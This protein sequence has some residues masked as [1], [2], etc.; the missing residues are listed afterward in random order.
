M[1]TKV[2]T[3]RAY[4]NT[5]LSI[6]APVVKILPKRYV[7][8]CAQGWGKFAFSIQTSFLSSWTE[9]HSALQ[10]FNFLAQV[11]FKFRVPNR[12]AII[13]VKLLLFLSSLHPCAV[14]SLVKIMHTF[15][16][17]SVCVSMIS[18]KFAR[19]MTLA[20]YVICSSLPV[21]GKSLSTMMT[22]LFR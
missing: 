20:F 16:L 1:T 18:E 13:D 9:F 11:A 4:W 21:N 12:K 14:S 7:C 3:E 15:T 6:G 2:Q 10:L 22:V 19:G 8:S 17:V 5:T